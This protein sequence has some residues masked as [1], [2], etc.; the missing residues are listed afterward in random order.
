MHFYWD[1]G[2][3]HFQIS[4]QHI[5]FHAFK[6]IEKIIKIKNVLSLVQHYGCQQYVVISKKNL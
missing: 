2:L 4:T 5:E 1:C 6:K 3:F